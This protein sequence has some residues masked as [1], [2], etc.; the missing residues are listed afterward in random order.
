MKQLNNRAKIRMGQ[1]NKT[2][3]ELRPAPVGSKSCVQTF[4][5]EVPHTENAGGSAVLLIRPKIHRDPIT[6]RYFLLS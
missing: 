4:G 1:F 6:K 5:K 2:T 3:G